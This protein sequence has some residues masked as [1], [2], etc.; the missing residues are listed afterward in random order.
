[1]ISKN[2][3]LIV[4]SIAQAMSLMEKTKTTVFCLRLV[5][6]ENASKVTER[7]LE[8]VI[9]EELSRPLACALLLL[10]KKI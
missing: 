7:D 4:K 6:V 2:H 8:T 3:A 9:S 10:P 1:M 5:F